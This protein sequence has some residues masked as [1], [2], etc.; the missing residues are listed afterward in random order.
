VSR[1]YRIRIA[2]SDRRYITVEDRVCT[3]IEL[4]PVLP[5]DRLSEL[6]AA[7]LGERGFAVK[8]GTATRRDGDVEIEVDL[9]TGRVSARL[10]KGANVARSASTVV[11][12]AADSELS[13][14]KD[15]EVRD[16][17]RAEVE[18]KMGRE[19]AKL[20]AEVTARLEGELRDLQAEVSEIESRVVGAALK[21]KAG[22]LGEIVELLEDESGG[23]TI[24]VKV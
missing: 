8:D 19:Q 3:D 6:L 23:M 24:K 4:L 9:E 2:E 12:V 11:T 21:E 22:Q 14:K 15:E 10:E 18:E 13:Q 7:E 17:L 1:A 16:Q 20:Q 5:A